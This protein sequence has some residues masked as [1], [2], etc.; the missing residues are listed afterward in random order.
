MRYFSVMGSRVTLSH[1][2]AYIRYVYCNF[3][4]RMFWFLIIVKDRVK[5]KI[6]PPF[7]RKVARLITCMI[8][9]CS[10]S[11]VV[12]WPPELYVRDLLSPSLNYFYLMLLVARKLYFEALYIWFA[13]SLE[14]SGTK[15]LGI[16]LLVSDIHE[17]DF[18]F[19]THQLQHQVP[20]SSCIHPWLMTVGDS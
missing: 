16:L 6:W 5:T 7:W 18:R 20:P 11:Q 17:S 19:T 13:Q 9:S 1:T 14:M 12:V 10:V 8:S 3:W 4:C 2:V 15:Y